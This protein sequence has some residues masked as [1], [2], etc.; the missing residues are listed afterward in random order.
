MPF[1][2]K[3]H[4]EKMQ[5]LL[6]QGQITPEHFNKLQSETPLNLVL[7]E[8]SKPGPKKKNPALAYTK[9]VTKR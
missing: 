4:K 5:K 2:S 1:K 7:P 3:S 6:E 8:K 9:K